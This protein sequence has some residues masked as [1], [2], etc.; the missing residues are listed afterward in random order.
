M[1]R[2]P[3]SL[4]ISGTLRRVEAKLLAISEVVQ[5]RKVVGWDIFQVDEEWFY[6]IRPDLGEVCPICESHAGITFRG[7][8]IPFTFPYKE[9]WTTSPYIVLPRTHM[10]NLED[11]G[12]EP[13]HC[14]LHLQNAAETLERRLHEE[15]LAVI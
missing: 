5:Y 3:L 14:E 7:D 6:V 4:V 8:Q 10:P 2:P 13:C 11:F 15:K 12:G 1:E 9:L